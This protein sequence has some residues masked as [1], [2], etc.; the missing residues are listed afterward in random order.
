MQLPKRV[1]NAGVGWVRFISCIVLD[2]VL[3]LT[4][5]LVPPIWLYTFLAP[6]TFYERLLAVVLTFLVFIIT[7]LCSFFFSA[8]FISKTTNW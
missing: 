1:Q 6:H 8:W 3:T 2:A 5:F 4:L 7:G